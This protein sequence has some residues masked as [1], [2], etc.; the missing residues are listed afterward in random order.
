MIVLDASLI[1]ENA[2]FI[3]KR[4]AA[5]KDVSIKEI[6][7]EMCGMSDIVYFS[8]MFPSWSIQRGLW[9]LPSLLFLVAGA[10]S[11]EQSPWTGMPMAT[12]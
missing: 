8:H 10:W 12:M 6:L 2:Y 3:K 7:N 11:A 4:E 5:Y 9:R 1:G